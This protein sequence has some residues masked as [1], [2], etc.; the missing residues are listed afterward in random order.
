MNSRT[1]STGSLS[2]TSDHPN[3][4]GISLETLRIDSVTDFDLYLPSH[5]RPPVLYRQ[6]Q[7][8]FSDEVRQRLVS[9]RVKRLLVSRNQKEAYQL[10]VERNLG[11]IL[12]DETLPLD[13]RSGLLYEASTHVIRQVIADP[14]AGDLLQRSSNI[15]ENTVTFL[16][17][18]PHAFRSLMRV[19]SFD[20]YTYT[21]SVNVFVFSMALAQHLPFEESE[22]RKFGYGALLHDIGKSQ[23]DPAI[24]NCKG[25]LDAEQWEQMRR[26]PGLGHVILIE[27]GVTNEI[28]LDVTLHHHEKLTGNGYPDGLPPEQIT[29]WVRVSTICD[30]FDALT[31]RRSYK[32]AMNSFPGLRLMRDEM[33]KEI[34]QDFFRVFVSLL[35]A[36]G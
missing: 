28:I 27:Q 1:D 19:M 14:R 11:L 31:T 16:Y 36:T 12:A 35:G 2:L 20:Y 24:V 6:A 26:H 21:H 7:L 33:S 4:F 32:P 34:D 15:V 9:A 29:P 22:L 25:K 8:P 30:I 10:Y 5:G 18:N 3:F 17:S 13:T 23:I